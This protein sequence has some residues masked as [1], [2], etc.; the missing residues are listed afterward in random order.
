MTKVGKPW[1]GGC[2]KLPDLHQRH[3]FPRT[4]HAP[5]LTAAKTC[6]ASDPK[7]LKGVRGTAVEARNNWPTEVQNS[8]GFF[9]EKHS[10]TVKLDKRVTMLMT[11]RT[12]AH[13]VCGGNRVI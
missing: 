11:I 6:E 13:R 7:V 4:Y 3:Q 9:K 12:R 10:K 5:G 1:P 2:G 8:N